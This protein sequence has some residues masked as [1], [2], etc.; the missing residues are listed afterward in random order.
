MSK[1]YEHLKEQVTV[2]QV[3]ELIERLNERIELLK[4]YAD[5]INK[6]VDIIQAR[7]GMGKEFLQA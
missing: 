6:R 4:E 2:E 3:I 1:V 7:Q 5:T